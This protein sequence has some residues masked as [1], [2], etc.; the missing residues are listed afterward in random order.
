MD[1]ILSSPPHPELRHV[2]RA[3]AQRQVQDDGSEVQPVVA[4]L[5]QIL[6]FEF[7]DP[8]TI[9][10][11]NGLVARTGQVS[12]VGAHS[13]ARASIRFS[14]K[15]ESF[16]VFFQ[17][18]GLWQLFRLPNRE[19]NDHAYGAPEVI[20]GGSLSRIW[21]R[22]AEAVNFHQRVAIMNDFLF[23]KAAGGLSQTPIMSAATHIF[24]NHGIRSLASAADGVG[25][26][27]RQFERRFLT[28]VGLSPKRFARIS[29]FQ[30]SL[31][32]K[33]RKPERT[34]ISIAHEFGYHDQM[35]MLHDF[36]DLGAASPG[37]LLAQIGDG[38]PPA[39]AASKLQP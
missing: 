30:M 33:V 9:E 31:D 34:W 18:F 20:A 6:Q 35:H 25:L 12:F 14:G 37:R 15:I 26:S 28:E 4:S 5:E 38:R 21:N 13:Y 27:L 17:P 1:R 2:V 16:A 39:L 32:A 11:R 22:M 8:L 24:R 29:R 10:Y 3:Y 7:G 19:L 36:S 23:Q